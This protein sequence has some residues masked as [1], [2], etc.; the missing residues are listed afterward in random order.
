MLFVK[1]FSSLFYLRDYFSSVS[2]LPLLAFFPKFQFGVFL[3]DGWSGM[4]EM[5]GNDNF[6]VIIDDILLRSVA[7]IRMFGNYSF[8]RPLN[9]K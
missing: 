5:E 8:L 3:M 2:S 6:M 7:L 1:L 4:G 9:E